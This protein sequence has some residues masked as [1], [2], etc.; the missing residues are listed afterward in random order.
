MVYVLIVL[1]LSYSMVVVRL[2]SAW[3][4]AVA[5]GF[6]AGRGDD[7][8][9]PFVSVVVAARNEQH[10]LPTL[11]E[12]LAGQDYPA[13][14][15]V[16]VDDDSTDATAMV[17]QQYAARDARFRLLTNAGAGKK[18][19]LTT[20]IATARGTVI[21]TTDADCRAGAS[22]LSGMALYF[23][24]P[25]VQMAFGPVRMRAGLTFF[26][27]LQQLEFASLIGAAAATFQLGRA[28]L[29]NGAN[30]AFRKAAFDAVGGYADNL[31]IPSGDDEFLM[32]K[33]LRDYPESLA[34]VNI[35][36]AIVTTAPQPTVKDFADQRLR[37]AGKWRHNTSFFTQVLAVYILLVQLAFAVLPVLVAVGV[38]PVVMLAVLAWRMIVEAGYLYAITRF[39]G[40]KFQTPAFVALQFLYPFYVVCIGLLSWVM[41]Y[42]W[43]GRTQRHASR[44]LAR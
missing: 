8:E 12:D 11:L 37:W 4:A 13:F 30:L 23:R 31:H 29:C 19:A 7:E 38:A 32:R 22:W 27:A 5:K 18:H 39:L 36:Q 6:A 40:V 3:N 25:A 21:V 33:V 17:V 2:T 1:L 35:S 15:V 16:V 42:R 14:E 24:R 9:S 10:T 26:S 20:A 28:T 43:K 34:F 44:P 41:P